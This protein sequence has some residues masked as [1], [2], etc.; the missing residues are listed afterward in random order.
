MH[1]HVHV[2][3]SSFLLSSSPQQIV[4]S[5]SQIMWCRDLTKCLSVKDG[6]VVEAVKGAEQRCFEVTMQ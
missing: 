3:V 1:I 2:H 5:V 4:I 6:E